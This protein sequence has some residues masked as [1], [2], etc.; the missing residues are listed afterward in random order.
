MKCPIFFYENNYNVYLFLKALSS[1]PKKTKRIINKTSINAKKKKQI[2]KYTI[3]T[4]E[5]PKGIEGLNNVI[6]I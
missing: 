3:K 6:V 5:P 2:I 1:F 4:G